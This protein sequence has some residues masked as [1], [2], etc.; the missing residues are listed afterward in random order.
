[1]SVLLWGRS[2][3]PVISGVASALV[4][5]GTDTLIADIDRIGEVD[6]DGPN[7]GRLLLRDGRQANLGEITGVLVRPGEPAD[8]AM[9]ASLAGW[10]EVTPARVL[11]R[12]SAG[13]TNSSKPYQLR[14]IEAVGFPVPDTL[15]TTVADDVRAFCLEHEKVVYKSTSGVR[16]VVALLDINDDDRLEDVS[17]CPTQFQAYIPGADHRVHVV[18]RELFACRVV[19]EAV[20]YRYAP[21]AGQTT[22]MLPVELPRHV[23][24]RCRMLAATLGL[25]LAGIDLRL[26]PDGRWWCFEVNTAPGLSWFEQHTAQPIAAAVA[27]R[28]A[29]PLS[30]E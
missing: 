26:D 4:E 23:A 6:V 7:D 22:A 15:V 28:L 30:T 2:D 20:D 12:L 25:E 16:S 5:V 9:Y 27:R 18:G 13:A 3:D 19:S 8:L 21:W 11:N 1:M 14:A 17:T 29:E 24:N 10:T